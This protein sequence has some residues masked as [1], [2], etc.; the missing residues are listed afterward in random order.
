MKTMVVFGGS[1]GLG[2]KLTPLLEKK[3][4]VVSLSS[5]DVDV[6]NFKEVERFFKYNTV[7]IVL[8]M[9]SIKYDTFLSKI[10][11]GD[12]EDIDT[13]RNKPRYKAVRDGCA[14]NC[15]TTH[16]KNCS[17]RELVP[18]LDVLGVHNHDQI[19]KASE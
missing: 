19:R 7:D 11:A 4:N 9:S 1:G 15:P 17:Y 8:N 18:L 12:E 3:Y 10:T 6:T 16:C 14:T 13:I 5:K 2:T